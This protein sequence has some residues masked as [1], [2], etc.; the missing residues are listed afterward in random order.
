[1]VDGNAAR[2]VFDPVVLADV[3]DALTEPDQVTDDRRVRNDVCRKH[4]Q[5]KHDLT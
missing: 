5:G 1:M 4:E 3:V 2:T